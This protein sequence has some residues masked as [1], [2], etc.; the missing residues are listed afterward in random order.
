M[1]HMRF[2]ILAISIPLLSLS[3]C[4]APATRVPTETL[5]EAHIKTITPE[6]RAAMAARIE[7]EAVGISTGTGSPNKAFVFFDP[8]CS[9]CFD[10]WRETQALRGQADFVWIPVGVLGGESTAL[11]AAILESGDVGGI[12]AANEASLRTFGDAIV[13]K[14]VPSAAALA[15]VAGNTELMTTL[16]PTAPIQAVP[17]MV[18]KSAAGRIELISGS[19]DAKALRAVLKPDV[20]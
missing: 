7:K 1:T 11:G 15:K 14:P 13:P 18:Y 9:Y 19:M 16:D 12:L 8:N 4:T 5:M 3:A 10:L 20:P 6:R 2:A 17:L